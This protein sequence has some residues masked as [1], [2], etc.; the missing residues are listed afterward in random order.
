MKNKGFTLIE[1][2]AAIAILA[3]LAVIVAP[4]VVK[5]LNDSEVTLQEQQINTIINATKKYVVENS[6][7]LPEENDQTRVNIST[8]IENGVIDNETVI[9]PKTKEVI[10][11]Y[12][13][14]T[15]SKEYNQYIYEFSGSDVQ[16]AFTYKPEIQSFIVSKTGYYKLEVWGAQG[17]SA[18]GKVG[19]YGGY[20]TGVVYLNKEDA[21]FV[22][23]GG[24]GGTASGTNSTVAGGYNGGGT[25]KINYSTTVYSGSGG[26][27]THIA[28]KTG[29]LSSLG[30][31]KDSI[32]I[33]AGGGGGA[34]YFEPAN[35]GNGGAGGGFKG[36]NG[37]S[38]YNRYGTGGTQTAGGYFSSSASHGI[39]SFGQGGTTGTNGS[40]AYG[41]AGGGGYYGGGAS[42]SDY[43]NG[44]GGGSGYIGNSL[45]T[46]KEMYC[47]S[48][49]ESSEEN[50][51]TISTTNV[52][53]TPTS[54]YAKEGNGYAR[55]TYIGKKL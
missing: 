15:Y 39:G 23:V 16:V 42:G 36:V 53:E 41:G 5:L 33:V 45:L 32:L 20:S 13:T 6:D 30:S 38:K 25:A 37:N 10:D 43:T 50:T 55:I 27:A 35:F 3:L 11:G 46:N 19:G 14:I 54:N 2:L 29:L 1:L 52:S 34:G 18:N 21:L 7:L 40:N 9:D 28:T 49:T 26:G 17:G 4:K 31:S 8:L 22:A 51:K 24:V 44:G 12:V 47:Y 48:C